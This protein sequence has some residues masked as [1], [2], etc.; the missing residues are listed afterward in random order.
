MSPGGLQDYNRAAKGCARRTFLVR[1]LYYF[2]AALMVIWKLDD[3]ED[4]RELGVRGA[5][6]GN[7]IV[8]EYTWYLPL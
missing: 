6:V 3:E 8:A 4:A 7:E 2:R 5:A 1:F